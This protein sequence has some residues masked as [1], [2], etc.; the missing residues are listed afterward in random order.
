MKRRTKYLL[1]IGAATL[2]LGGVALASGVSNFDVIV[3]NAI[4]T[5]TSTIT[6]IVAQSGQFIGLGGTPPTGT[7]LGVTGDSAKTLAP[8]K[9]KTGTGVVD[10]SVDAN[11]G[12]T[13]QTSNATTQSLRV[14]GFT[15]QSAD[16]VDILNNASV[17]MDSFDANGDLLI[18]NTSASLVPF[19]IIQQASPTA[20][21]LD[22]KNSGGTV[23]DNLD[24]QGDLAVHHIGSNAGGVYTAPTVSACGTSPSLQAGSSDSSG[25]I[26]VGSGTVTACL[27]TFGQAYVNKPACSVTTATGAI[28]TFSATPTTTNVNIQ[29]ATNFATDTVNYVCLGT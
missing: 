29:S 1:G 6:N 4:N 9:V 10:L 8:L 22:I 19:T 26:T 27:V 28:V 24:A 2:A 13:L 17:L 11:G 20:D 14:F 21:L 7:V 16:I 25:I 5:T 15:S 12:T 23:M 3:A 18:D